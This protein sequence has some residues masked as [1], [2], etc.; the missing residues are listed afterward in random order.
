VSAPPDEFLRF[1]EEQRRD[2]RLSLPEKLEQIEAL[3]A[4]LA[5][6]APD[7]LERLERLAHGIAGSGATFGFA[8]LGNAAKALELS[9]QALR[10]SE[11]AAAA[12]HHDDIIAALRGLKS[13][14]PP[15]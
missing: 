11:R 9:V 14:L 2:Y 3:A 5:G 4:E 6:A 8:E 15:P 1:L 10:R 7:A 12:P 13:K